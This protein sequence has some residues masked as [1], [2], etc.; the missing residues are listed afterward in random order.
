LLRSNYDEFDGLKLEE[1][2]FY[3]VKQSNTVNLGGVDVEEVVDEEELE[4]F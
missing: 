3:P 2:K 4:L 1:L